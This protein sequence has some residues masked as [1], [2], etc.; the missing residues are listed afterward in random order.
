MCSRK[1]EAVQGFL[2]D[3]HCSG[4]D[5]IFIIIIWQN[6]VDPGERQRDVKLRKGKVL[7]LESRA[8]VK[9]LI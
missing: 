4:A 8:Q 7:K 1:H 9:F 2:I 6:I 5:N 3:F